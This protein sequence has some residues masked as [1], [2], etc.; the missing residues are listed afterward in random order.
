MAYV[1]YDTKEE[2]DKLL[3]KIKMRQQRAVTLLRESIKS[4]DVDVVDI[5]EEG[6]NKYEFGIKKTEIKE[7]LEIEEIEKEVEHD[8]REQYLEHDIEEWLF[9]MF[10]G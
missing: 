3:E 9:R 10:D 4:E 7:E 5:E 2:H 6:N 1:V 8:G